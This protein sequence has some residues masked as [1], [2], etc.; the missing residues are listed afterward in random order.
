MVRTRLGISVFAAAIAPLAACSSSKSSGPADGGGTDA[1]SPSSGGGP[2][3]SSGSGSGS[4]GSTSASGSGSGSGGGSSSSGALDGGSCT[5]GFGVMNLG[6]V[7]D[8][9]NLDCSGI[10]LPY[11]PE[12]GASGSFSATGA[13]A[14]KAVG[15]ACGQCEFA[16]LQA[17][18]DALPSV[19]SSRI[20]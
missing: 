2:G 13:A 8:Q 16:L 4:S 17:T 7:C 20:C 18:C 15:D 12:F 3:S 14:L 6:V 5:T 19:Q 9:P 1:A 10:T 11:S